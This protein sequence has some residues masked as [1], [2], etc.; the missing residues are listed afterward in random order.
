MQLARDLQLAHIAIHAP[1][2]AVDPTSFFQGAQEQHPWLARCD[3]GLLVTEYQA[4]KELMSLDDK[5]RNP[6]TQIVELMGAQGTG[7]GRFCEEMML[8]SSG[9]RH[10]RLRG[11]V[12]NAFTPRAVNQLRPTMRAVISDL[13]DEWAPRGAFD[14]VEF[15]SQFPIRVMFGVIGADP[16]VIPEIQRSLEIHGASFDL[17]PAKMPIIEQAYQHLWGFVDDLIVERGPDGK[18]GDLLDQLIAVNSSGVISAAE[19]RQM[20]I[21]L[22]AAGF[23]TTKNT[24]S[25]LLYATMG[26]PELWR[27]CAMDRPYC[28]KV[29]EES[30]RL[31][32]PSSTYREV[33]EGFGYR[34]VAFGVGDVLIFPVSIAGRDTAAFPEPVRFDPERVHANRH[35][36]FGRG[37]HMCLGQFMARA[38]IEE[39][40]H[41]I[42]QRITNP[43]LTGEV[44]W[45]PFPGT[46]GIKSLPIAFQPGAKGPEAAMRRSEVQ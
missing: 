35:L 24:L 39:G 2:V 13:L 33:T 18:Q 27:R 22:F 15:A 30:L 14:F 25:L 23:D 12:A 20:L 21:L 41:L 4:M 45:R 5:L 46:W 42:A 40:L 38:N 37:M 34:D 1:E 43:R 16:K 28:D 9:E 10:A 7:W 3:A 17:N 11:S 44:S 36:A 6:S 29:V 8:S 19:L 31:A 32:S 26:E